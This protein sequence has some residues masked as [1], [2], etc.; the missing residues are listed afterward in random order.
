MQSIDALVLSL[1][2]PLTVVYFL[3]GLDGFLTDV[4]SL[5][6]RARPKR[7]GP[8]DL[9]EIHAL[10]EKRIAVMVASWK[11]IGVLGK[12]VRG[13][14]AQIRYRNYDFFLGV[15][16]NDAATCREAM[17]LAQEFPNVH[18]VVNRMPGPT[19]KGQMLNQVVRHILGFEKA[20]DVRF[21]AFLIHDSEDLIHREALKIINWQLTRHDFVQVP[22]F[23]LP[24]SWSQW[25]AGTYIDEFSEWH[26]K[27]ILVRGAL[28]QSIPSAGVGTALSRRLVLTYLE[29]QGALLNERSLTEDYEL[30]V[31]TSKYGLTSVLACYYAEDFHGNRDY[32]A[33][34]EYFPKSF[35]RSVKQKARWTLGI[36]FQGTEHLG[37]SG[38]LLQKYYYFQDR[39]GPFNH[40]VVALGVV[41]FAYLVARGALFGG[42]PFPEPEWSREFALVFSANVFL[43][44]NRLFQRAYCVARVYGPGIALWVPARVLVGNLINALAALKA[45][46]QYVSSKISGEAPRW[47][48]TEHELPVGFGEKA[49]VTAERQKAG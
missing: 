28:G 5:F 30:G 6:L 23:S 29:Q 45:T 47:V 17:S 20:A 37:W 24:V 41:V 21:D 22:I 8:A 49:V 44:C 35:L 4:L 11:E 43:M 15:Y 7:L 9:D 18:V 39:K 31:T 46:Q 2:V 40:L 33:T 26:T 3:F 42:A 16:P 27:D 12:M 32:I 38:G 14:S 1:I 25:V 10:P 19:S 13:N 48:K 34:R 36:A